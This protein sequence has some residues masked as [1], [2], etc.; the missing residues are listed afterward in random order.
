MQVD[1]LSLDWAANALL[2]ST[3]GTVKVT[4]VE[5]QDE[6]LLAFTPIAYTPV[7]G[8]WS[9]FFDGSA[10]KLTAGDEDVTAAAMDEAGQL[11]LATKG[12]Y[13][14]F[15]LSAIQGDNNDL[16][17]CTLSS[18]GLNTTACTFFAF[19]DGDFARFRQPIDGIGFSFSASTMLVAASSTAEDADPVQ[20][21]V[22]PDERVSNDPELDSFDIES[23]TGDAVVRLYLPVV[24]C[25]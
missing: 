16:F 17:G 12:N 8:T 18:S 11:Y 21:E 14:A 1:F 25:E 9:L 15:S 23:E 22:I 6:D 7:P 19:F 3:E 4:G 10:V 2:I 13:S 5:G 20:F 24:V